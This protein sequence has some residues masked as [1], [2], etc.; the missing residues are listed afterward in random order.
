MA[1][2]PAEPEGIHVVNVT[3]WFHD[4]VDIEP[5]L[6]FGLIAGGRSNM[7]FTV[8]DQAERRFVLRRPPMGPLLP[9]AHDVAREHRLMYAL[10]DSPV[11]V[12]ELVGLCQDEAV[13]DRDF[14][15][16]HFLD[17][18]IVRDAEIGAT[19]EEA[20]RTRMSHELIDTLVALHRVDIDEVGLGNLAK[21]SG[22]IERQIKRWSGQWDQSKT[23]EL[24]VI[25]R[26]A[27]H[28]R[29]NLPPNAQ[30]TIAHGDYRLSNCMMDPT[31]PVAGVLDWELCTLGDPMADLAGLLGY[32]FDPE[33]EDAQ[34]DVETTGLPGF[35]SQQEMAGLYAEEMG[36]SLDLVDYYRGFA[37]WRLACIAE[38]VYARYLNGQQGSQD[39]ELDLDEYKVSVERRADRSAE[40]L[41]I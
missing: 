25:E 36:V 13:N 23:R 15:V 33:G 32:W 10:Q 40:L 41:G 20:A 39:E 2:E 24:P 28:L 1:I 27:D 29:A 16:M 3:N 6:E 37:A 9:S 22:Y 34:G 30:T 31:G 38:G 14:Y 5:P 21:R 4:H 18:V 19:I 26:V 8:T 7:T 17:G 12:P 11:P 35:L